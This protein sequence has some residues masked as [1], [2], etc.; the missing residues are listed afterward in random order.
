MQNKNILFC[1]YLLLFFVSCKDSEKLDEG[2]LTKKIPVL[3]VGTFH[4]AET[5]DQ[6]K[7]EFDLNNENNKKDLNR[8]DSLLA[9]FKPTIILVE[10]EP[11]YQSILTE[12]FEAYKKNP[13]LE[14][15]FNGEVKYIAYEV[16]RLANTSKIMAIDHQMGYDYMKIDK[17]A[18]EIDAK[19]YLKGY[20]S[21]LKT[22]I[23]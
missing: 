21:A 11:E 8:L 6:H 16:G 3:N 9:Q 14:T 5:S 13:K 22:I 2:E 4:M 20:D 1:I 15:K 18:H 17:L 7:T 23:P 10:V 12:D 19:T